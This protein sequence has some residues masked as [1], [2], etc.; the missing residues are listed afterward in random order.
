MEQQ[1]KEWMNIEHMFTF[2]VPINPMMQIT[3]AKI[4]AANMALLYYQD[5]LGL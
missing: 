3:V 2:T 4:S 5:V 1:K